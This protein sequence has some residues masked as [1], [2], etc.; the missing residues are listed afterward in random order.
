LERSFAKKQSAQNGKGLP[1]IGA[2]TSAIDL[3][4]S[5]TLPTVFPFSV[6]TRTDIPGAC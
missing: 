6:L 4:R 5:F 2:G 3:A 1:E